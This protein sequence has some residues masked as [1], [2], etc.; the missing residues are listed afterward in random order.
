MKKI[1]DKTFIKFVIVGII[2]TAVG[3]GV[4]FSMYNIF[5]FSYWISTATNYIA[6]SIISYF[7]NKYFT[8]KNTETGIE[9]IIRFSLNIIICYLIA[10]GMA[11]PFVKL[12]LSGQ[13]ET[14]RDNFAMSFGMILFVFLNYFGQRFFAFKSR[15]GITNDWEE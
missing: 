3:T 1:L 2:N 4:M 15:S 7:L 10:Y 12:I 13:S 9:P 6:G 11:K 5:H 8:F 14:F